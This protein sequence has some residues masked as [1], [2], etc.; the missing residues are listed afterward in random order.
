MPTAP[1]TYREIFF[2]K[3]SDGTYREFPF[4]LI[5]V[6]GIG[7]LVEPRPMNLM[8][9]GRGSPFDESVNKITIA[10]RAEI[11]GI[12]GLGDIQAPASW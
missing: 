2:E 10:K 12:L 4:A 7:A 3:L 1:I 9:P 11:L 6:A 8:V 5:E